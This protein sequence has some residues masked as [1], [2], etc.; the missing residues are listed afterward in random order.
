MTGTYCFKTGF[1]AL[2]DL[3][4][5]F[6]KAIESTSAGLNNKFC[7]LDDILI[8]SRGRIENHLDLMRK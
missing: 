8:V 7:F 5:E 3:P 4:A 1:Y 6:Q 2:T